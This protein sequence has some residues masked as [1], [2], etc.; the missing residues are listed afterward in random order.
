MPS[1]K[2]LFEDAELLAAYPHFTQLLEELQT[3]SVFRPQIPDYSQ[4]S[5]ILQTNLWRVLVGAAT[6]ENAMEQAAKQ[7]RSLLKNGVLNQG[8]SQ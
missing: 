5:K 3:R 6:P 1:R 4:A 2:A 8:L 7:T